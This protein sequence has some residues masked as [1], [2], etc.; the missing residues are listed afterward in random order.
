MSVQIVVPCKWTDD[1]KQF[2]LN[3]FDTIKDCPARIY[4]SIIIPCPPSSWLHKHYTTELSK[5]IK[6]VVG[7]PGWGTCM[8]TINHSTSILAYS[9]NTIATGSQPGGDIIL[10]D[11]LTGSQI[12]V[13]SG[14]V[15]EIDSLVFSLD[16]TLLVSG[17]VDKTVKLWDVQTGGVIK[18]H[19]GHTELVWSV[20]I[21]ADN[22]VIA[23]GSFDM[24]IHL[25]NIKT[26]DCHIIEQHALFITVTFSPTNPK[27]LL[28][29]SRDG[30][31]QQWGIDG[32]Q[33]GPPIAGYHVVF[34]PD[35]TYFLVRNKT[36]VTII[37]TNSRLAVKKFS[38]DD[39]KYSFSPNG[40]FIAGYNSH[41]INLWDIT[42][43]TPHLIQTL[44]GHT[45]LIYSL[46]FAS[47]F[48]LISASNDNSIKFWQ[49]GALLE[50][51]VALDSES[52][53]LTSA[54]I[55]AVS[56][57]T[58]DG[59]AFSIDSQGVV[60][61]WDIVIARVALCYFC[62]N[63]F[64]L[65]SPTLTPF[66]SYPFLFICFH[67]YT[68]FIFPFSQQSRDNKDIRRI[69]S[70]YTGGGIY[71]GGSGYSGT[72]LMSS[73]ALSLLKFLS[74]SHTSSTGIKQP[75]NSPGVISL[76][77]WIT[78][79]VMSSIRTSRPGSLSST[80]STSSSNNSS[81]TIGFPGPC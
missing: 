50:D 4:D 12:S 31:V 62:S 44:A 27:L 71:S 60:R 69:Y 34:S 58:K 68:H 16:G 53:S 73:V 32:Q 47:S 61:T 70:S 59:L 78:S 17:S 33:V 64:I 57:Q 2:I 8:R 79:G 76:T 75:A 77:S 39:R 38:S 24:T 30:T 72:G 36:T 25:W 20:S 46:A 55:R 6:V 49:V 14:H 23:S 45:D 35:G 15:R 80:T 3:N 11:T 41:D 65:L 22:T 81:T 48:T 67:L 19:C 29:S 42:G 26:G 37:N 10:F 7:P 51:Q 1:G 40:R 5:K 52:I 54:P 66:V 74:S 56:L 13:L 63:S 21:S 28:S 18:T 9:N 43:Q